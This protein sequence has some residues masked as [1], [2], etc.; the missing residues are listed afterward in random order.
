M[1]QILDYNP[2]NDGNNRGN[3]GNSKD[4]DKIIKVFAILLIFFAICLIGI[5]V[6]NKI[7]NNF[8]ILL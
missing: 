4:T 5:G 1:N 2:I 6:Y 3:G 7:N 8:N